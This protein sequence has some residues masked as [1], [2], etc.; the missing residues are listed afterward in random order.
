MDEVRR[1][2]LKEIARAVGGRLVGKDAEVL[3]FTQDSREARRGSLFFAIRGEKLDGHAFVGDALRRGAVAAVVE[4][5]PGGME[6]NFV[7][8]EDTVKALQRLAV[9]YRKSRLKGTDVIAIGGAAG[10]TTTK[11]MLYRVLS[12][13]YRTHRSPRS[14]NNHI[15][16]PLTLL[17]TPPDTRFLVL[18]VGTNHPGEVE[19]LVN[20]ALNRYG[21]LTNIGPEHIEFFGSEEAI[22]REESHVFLHAQAGFA[23]K[24][25]IERFRDFMILPDTLHHPPPLKEALKR[26]QRR[27]VGV[28]FGGIYFPN[29][30]WL[31]NALMV[32]VAGRHFGIENPMEHL[33]D[34][35]SESMRMEILRVG[36][37]EVI[38]D[39]YNSNPLSLRALFMSIRPSDANLFVLGDM[40]ELGK[41]SGQYH[42]Q[43][44]REM[45]K[46]GHRDAILIGKHMRHFYDEIRDMARVDHFEGV[47]E[48]IG[49]IKERLRGRRRLIL[50]GS[51]GIGLERILRHL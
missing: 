6:G 37:L 19:F 13:R 9:H 8:V 4:R 2:T 42:R 26:A 40:L 32:E 51:R 29:V 45:V 15:G 20:M 28:V 46:M 3:H 21:L 44:A 48:A 14:Y 12:S 5:L 47:E 18:E 7:L 22:A 33:R 27:E 49:R 31:E 34:F 39:A 35:K 38:N 17:N 30:A 41:F 11:E 16:V 1:L 25:D 43:L 10:K 23:R 50:K 36:S 24:E